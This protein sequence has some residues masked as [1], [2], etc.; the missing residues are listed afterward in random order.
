MAT[1]RKQLPAVSPEDLLFQ[2]MPRDVRMLQQ[3]A[4]ALRR[5]K[6]REDFVNGQMADSNTLGGR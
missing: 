5:K 4:K 2:D 1:K 6:Q 3:N